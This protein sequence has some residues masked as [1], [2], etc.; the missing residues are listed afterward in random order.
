[1][2]L[3]TLQNYQMNLVSS[4]DCHSTGLQREGESEPRVEGSSP[5]LGMHRS[6]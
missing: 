3:A 1:M 6:T 4:R 2:N 5:A